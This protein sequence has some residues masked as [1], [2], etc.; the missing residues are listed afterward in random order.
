MVYLF[1]QCIRLT[2]TSTS[3]K[4]LVE[5]YKLLRIHDM[6]LVLIGFIKMTKL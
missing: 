3:H 6:T 2:I 5:F 4:Y 1:V